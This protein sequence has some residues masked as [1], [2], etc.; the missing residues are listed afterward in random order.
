MES[1]AAAVRVG[2]VQ[3]TCGDEPGANLDKAVRRIEMAARRGAQIVCLQELFCSVYFCQREDTSCFRLAE[4]IPGPTTET[5]SRVARD[6]QVVLIAPIFEK[7]AAGLFHNAVAVIDADGTLL[8]TYRK[9]HI[10]DDPLYYEKFYFTPGDLGFQTFTTRYARVGVLICWDQWF[11][12]AARLTALGGAQLLFY[13][14]A[15]GWHHAE[16]AE[17]RQ[18][19]VTPGRQSSAAMRLP[20]GCLWR[21]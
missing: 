21:R 11:P 14:T 17:E 20:T 2:L 12:E 3:M 4:P 16:C 1:S 8:G 7:R 9:M 18:R 19:S 6:R 10:P 15:I 13:P 5:L